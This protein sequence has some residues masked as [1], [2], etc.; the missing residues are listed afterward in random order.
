MKLVFSS[1]IFASAVTSASATCAIRGNNAASIIMGENG[2]F[3]DPTNGALSS[4]DCNN[5]NRA[6]AICERFISIN[7]DEWCYGGFPSLSS[8]QDQ[9]WDR[10]QMLEVE[11]VGEDD[12][13]EKDMDAEDAPVLA[14]SYLRARRARCGKYTAG[15]AAAQ[16]GVNIVNGLWLDSGKDCRYATRQFS[17]DV[18]SALNA[19]FPNNCRDTGAYDANASGVR[20]GQN[21]MNRI[22]I[23]ALAAAHVAAETLTVE[24][25]SHRT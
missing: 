22:I 2:C 16:E 6:A 23:D 15:T 1:A 3:P 5:P 4:D 11:S 21:Y 19:E 7:Y 24:S 25:G 12:E 20:A 13:E 9:C 14:D 10:V 17:D 18:Q 8:L